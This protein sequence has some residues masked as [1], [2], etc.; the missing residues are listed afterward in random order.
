MRLASVSNHTKGIL[1]VLCAALVYGFYPASTR[2]AYMDGANVVFMILLTSFFRSF[3]IAA[4]TC[5]QKQPL[6]ATKDDFK[7]SIIN[8]VFQVLS[9][10]GIL[11]GMAFIS[12]PMV[13]TIMFSYVMLLY[14]FTVFRGEDSLS[15]PMVFIIATALA[16]LALVVDLKNNLHIESLLGI[17]LAFM[18]A[19][20]NVIRIYMLGKIMKT[21]NA[22]VV[23]AE[24]TLIAFI[25]CGGLLFFKA[26][27]APET[28]T[29]LSW[30][31]LAAISLSIGNFCMYYALS[32]ITSFEFSFFI[33]LELVFGAII[34]A[35]LVND[36]LNLSQ[37]LGIALVIGSLMIFQTIRK[38]KTS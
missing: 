28:L 3:S 13:M 16:G 14:L 19:L 8:G 20:S 29:G 35:L 22:Y 23:G 18:A 33:K 4:L 11:G 9:I 17:G 30:A 5:F 34:S 6:F 36:I 32:R 25:L 7:L 10:F 15:L 21:R 37:Y 26:P 2:G 31:L 38:E 27:I 24:M 12:G 1:A